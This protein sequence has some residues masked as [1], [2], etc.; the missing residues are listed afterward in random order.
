[1]ASDYEQDGRKYQVGEVLETNEGNMHVH[2]VSYQER[3]NDNGEVERHNFS[4]T[5]RHEDDVKADE[6]AAAEAEQAQKAQE[7]LAQDRATE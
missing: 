2:G 7:A 1:M 3:V 6:K 5:L 4:Y